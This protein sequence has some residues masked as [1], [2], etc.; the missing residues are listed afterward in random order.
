MRKIAGMTITAGL[1]A[2]ALSAPVAQAQEPPP[3][4]RGGELKCSNN[5]SF[6]SI[7]KATLIWT[8]P[9]VLT[10]SQVFSCGN[11]TPDP[12]DPPAIQTV[13]QPAA[14]TGWTLDIT[15]YGVIP[16]DPPSPPGQSSCVPD[17]G[18]FDAGGVPHIRFKCTNPFGPGSA[19]FTLSRNP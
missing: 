8:G 5:L 13:N 1:V 10:N 7:V 6:V 12:L 15:I 19:T 16:T 3:I 4:P 11:P 2:L 17:T 9:G 14:A 18:S